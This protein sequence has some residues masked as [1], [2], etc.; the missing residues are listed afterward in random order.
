MIPMSSRLTQMVQT[1]LTIK[2]FAICFVSVHVPLLVFIA[3]LA[4][5]YAAKPEPVLLLLLAATVAGT[6]ICL[7]SLWWVIRPLRQ[8]AH[9]IKIYRANGTPVRMQIDRKDEIGLLAST[10]T[11]MVAET[12]TLMTKLRHQAMTDLL[13]G[14]GN[15]RWLNERAA[16]ELARAERLGEPL[17]VLVLDLDRFKGINDGHGH[18]TGDR[19]LVAT[20]EIVRTC[21]R[22]YD[23]AA[24]IGG[25]EFCIMLPRTSLD[26]AEAIGERLRTTLAT[27]TV[28]PLR[29]GRMTASFGLCAAGPGD[30]LPDL[31]LRADFALYE[32]KRDGRNC[33]R[34]AQEGH[35]EEAMT[36]AKRVPVKAASPING[37]HI[38]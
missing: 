31:L 13:T 4:A 15:R 32:A 9:A 19:V 10:V 25:E 12:E 37:K 5:G 22:P 20:G 7:L 2:V 33:I 16:E 36:S 28:P 27:T 21:L 38:L 14:L 8:L 34:R 17:S 23:L 35:G 30:R 18:E 26:E 29:Q 11:A 6:T 1:S 24:R 3:F